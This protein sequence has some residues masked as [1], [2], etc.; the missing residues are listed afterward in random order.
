MKKFIFLSTVLIMCQIMSAQ[1]TVSSSGNVAMTKNVAVAGAS[2]LD[3]VALNVG[4]VSAINYRSFGVYAKQVYPFSSFSGCYAS[5]DG[6]V[7]YPE[8]I[9]PPI[10][11]ALPVVFTSFK[12]GV[13][14]IASSGCGVYGAIGSV[15]PNSWS[16]GNFAG[17]FNGNV[18]VTGSISATSVNTTSDL[19]VKKDIS[20]L[21]DS[22]MRMLSLLRPVSFLYDN[23]DSL[24]YLDESEYKRTHYGFIAQ[25]IKEII[26]DI[27]IEDAAGYLSVNYIELIPLL[28][29]TVKQ[30]QEQIEDLQNVLYGAKQNKIRGNQEAG[31]TSVAQLM[32]NTP[33]PFTQST[34]IGYYLPIDTREAAIRVY[35]MSGSE[36]VA[37]PIDS[38]GQ[39]ELTIDGGTLRAGMYLY[40]LI[41]DG[42]LIDTKQ[43]ILTK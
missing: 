22:S 16:A 37:F 8:Q 41:A 27:V 26:P 12:A 4:H 38:F 43:M 13:A 39:G 40:S 35:D 28:V 23:K 29:Q 24:L 6:R 25:E 1:L 11:G 34:K 21:D 9:N 42:Q 2:I 36:I 20:N 15:L 5:V 32:Q 31:H 10:T 33:N 30:Q 7:T 17:Y 14:G 19:R 18:K 3:S